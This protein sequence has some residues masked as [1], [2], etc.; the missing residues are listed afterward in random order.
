MLKKLKPR[1]VHVSLYESEGRIHAHSVNFKLNGKLPIHFPLLPPGEQGLSNEEFKSFDEAR[2]EYYR[3]QERVA[4][5]IAEALE[6]VEFEVD[7]EP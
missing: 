3:T 2:K 7:V 4:K 1:E 6:Q 5:A